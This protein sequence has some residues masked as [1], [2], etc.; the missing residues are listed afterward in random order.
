MTLRSFQGVCQDHQ[1]SLHSAVQPL[2]PE[3]GRSQRHSQHQQ[4]GGGAASRA[5]HHQ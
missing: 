3:R 5:G 2:H 4:R 1:A